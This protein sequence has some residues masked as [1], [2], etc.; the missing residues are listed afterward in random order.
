MPRHCVDAIAPSVD[1]D[2]YCARIGYAGSRAPTL[3]V[4]QALHM[5]HPT[6]ITFENLDPLL[7]R[8]V[9]LDASSLQRKLVHDRRG[10]YCFEHNLL[11]SH[12]LRTLGFRVRELAAR[13]LWSTPAGKIMPR[14]HMLLQVD[15]DVPYLADVGFGGLTLTAPLRLETREE[16]ITPHE[17]FRVVADTDGFVLQAEL[18]GTWKPVYEFDLQEQAL[19]DYEVANWYHCTNSDS[20]FNTTLV[21][22]R[23]AAGRRYALR[24]S[25]FVIHDLRGNTERRTLRTAAELRE[26]LTG[27]FGLTLPPDRGLD[28]VLERFVAPAAATIERR[29]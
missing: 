12:V 2:A 14:V 21:A 5:L 4:L 27:P 20:H 3:D 24:N 29:A 28:A 11:F 15:V 10:G 1:L 18:R 23:P 7:R 16:Q 22:A 13:V 25:E 8:P 6:A 19:A 9:L 17:T 26:V